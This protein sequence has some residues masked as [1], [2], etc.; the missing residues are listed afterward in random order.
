[1]VTRFSLAGWHRFKY[2]QL[3][4][5]VL[6]FFVLLFFHCTRQWAFFFRNLGTVALCFS[7][8]K[9][10]HYKYK[11]QSQQVLVK[12]LSMKTSLFYMGGHDISRWNHYRI[13]ERKNDPTWLFGRRLT[14]VNA[15]WENLF[16]TVW[17]I[18]EGD[19]FF[20]IRLYTDSMKNKGA[21]NELTNQGG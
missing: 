1:M 7:I 4:L 13:I 16:T 21:K 20:Y 6:G 14:N 3:S 5:A 10:W 18:S 8:S 9:F 15:L 12:K 2:L 17:S 19:V 11:F